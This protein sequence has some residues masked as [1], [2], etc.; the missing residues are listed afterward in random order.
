M[1]EQKIKEK[2]LAWV[3]SHGLQGGEGKGVTLNKPSS[4]LY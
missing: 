3:S 4:G 2:T 1:F